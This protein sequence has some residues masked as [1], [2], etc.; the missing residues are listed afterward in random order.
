MAPKMELNGIA[1]EISHTDFM[2]M[3]EATAPYDQIYYTP[4]GH[5]ELEE[6]W[7]DRDKETV[8]V[9]LAPIKLPPKAV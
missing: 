2:L 4:I 3:L 6:V 8:F 1:F 5:V 7:Y 9:S